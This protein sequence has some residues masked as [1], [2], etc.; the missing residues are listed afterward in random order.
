MSNNKEIYKSDNGTTEIEKDIKGREIKA[1]FKD[2]NGQIKSSRETIYN[3]K[4]S[5]QTEITRQIYMDA[6]GK[7]TSA[8]EYTYDKW[9]NQV[10]FGSIRTM[11]KEEKLLQLAVKMKIVS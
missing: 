8:D 2:I 9:G 3:D 1:I 6:N 11:I 7:I 5:K 10:Y 4:S